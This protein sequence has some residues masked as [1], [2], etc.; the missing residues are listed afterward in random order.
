M[1]ASP[2]DIKVNQKTNKTHSENS[3]LKEKELKNDSPPSQVPHIKIFQTSQ[4]YFASVG[5]SPHLATHEYPLNGKIVLGFLILG[6]EFIC[7]FVYIFDEAEEFVEYTQSICMCSL[8][9][10]INVILLVV[11]FNVELFFHT[12]FD[13]EDIVNTSE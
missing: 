8:V 6:S 13:S 7:L 11:I 5:I 12:I 9:A 1:A 2:A 3:N 10:L 4:K